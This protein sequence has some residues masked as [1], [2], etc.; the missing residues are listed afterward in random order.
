MSFDP[1][2]IVVLVGFGDS[3]LPSTCRQSD[4]ELHVTRAGGGFCSECFYRCGA[5]SVFLTAESWYYGRR[6]GAGH[7]FFGANDAI[8]VW[9]V[10]KR[11]GRRIWSI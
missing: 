9:S 8:D 1:D 2:R 6:E 4:V 7:S 3:S 5:R 11:L 10:K